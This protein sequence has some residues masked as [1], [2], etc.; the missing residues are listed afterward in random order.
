MV[1]SNSD[2]YVVDGEDDYVVG[3]VDDDDSDGKNGFVQL[4]IQ[5]GGQ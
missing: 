1:Y 4:N 3:N 5:R 2:G